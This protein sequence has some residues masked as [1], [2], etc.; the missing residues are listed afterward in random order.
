MNVLR[1]PS[2]TASS[3]L[4]R[5]RR[6]QNQL[7][8]PKAMY[9][10]SL[11]D[12]RTPSLRVH[13]GETTEEAGITPPTNQASA[14]NLCRRYPCSWQSQF[15]LLLTFTGPNLFLWALAQSQTCSCP[16]CD[17][18]SISLLVSR[19]HRQLG[20]VVAMSLT[21]FCGS[22]GRETRNRT[23]KHAGAFCKPNLA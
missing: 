22:R 19:W 3:I 15:R 14:G 16:S 11:A 9:S 13:R 12:N 20:I 21:G 7:T 10:P 18:S 2:E 17:D 1:R 23:C 8:I 5:L 6:R 4:L